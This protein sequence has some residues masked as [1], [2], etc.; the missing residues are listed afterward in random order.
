MYPRYLNY[1]DAQK[2]KYCHIN[3]QVSPRQLN[4]L[5]CSLEFLDEKHHKEHL[6]ARDHLYAVQVGFYAV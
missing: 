1:I 3:V 5:L 6:K 4:C 2:L